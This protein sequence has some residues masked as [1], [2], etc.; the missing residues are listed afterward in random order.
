MSHSGDAIEPG[1]NF[2]SDATLPPIR[3]YAALTALQYERFSL[4][5]DGT[6]NTEPEPWEAAKELKDV[7]VKYQPLCLTLAAL[8]HTVGEP[9][10]PGIEVLWVARRP[11]V[12]ALEMDTDKEGV[13][14]PFRV[15]H[16]VML[17]GHLTRG[18]SLPWQSD[19]DQCTTHWYVTGAT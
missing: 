15:N 2:P 8:D 17:P 5:R 6:F 18:L 10:F 13:D 9:L 19:F 4:W 3:R 1:L 16:E 11:E 12:Y 7:E 14:P